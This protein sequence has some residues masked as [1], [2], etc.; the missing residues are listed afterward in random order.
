MFFCIFFAKFGP[1]STCLQKQKGLIFVPCNDVFAVEIVQKS[2]NS[3]EAV[4]SVEV[5]PSLL[6]FLCLAIVCL[7]V[8]FFQLCPSTLTILSCLSAFEK[9]QYAEQRQ[10]LQKITICTFHSF[11]NK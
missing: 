3:V 1:L 6:V 4:Y 11:P 2:V 7:L 9:Q 5:P 8:I 10:F